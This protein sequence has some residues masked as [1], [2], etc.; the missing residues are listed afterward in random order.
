MQALIDKTVDPLSKCYVDDY[1]ALDSKT[2]VSLIQLLAS[3]RDK[4]TEPALK[5]AFTEFREAAPRQ[6]RPKR[7]PSDVKWAAKA[8]GDLKLES[9]AGLADAGSLSVSCAPARMLGGVAVPRHTAARSRSAWRKA[10]RSRAYIGPLIQLL[11][12]QK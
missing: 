7:R 5:K 4:R 11:E 12:V 8:T 2:R 1:A 3:F 10:E 6:N 9:L